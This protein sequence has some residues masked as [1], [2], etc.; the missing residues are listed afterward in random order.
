MP[1]HYLVDGYNVV[2]KSSL[3]RP[4]ALRDFETAREMFI[5]KVV[6]FCL[7]SRQ[8]VTV[9]FDGRDAFSRVHEGRNTRGVQ[10]LEVVYSPDG[11]SADAVIERMVYA[12]PKRLE[13][14]VVSNDGGLRQLCRGLGAL[15]MEP[16]HFIRTVRAQQGVLRE[17]IER[18]SR[19]AAQ[20][21]LLEDRLDGASFDRLKALRDNLDKKKKPGG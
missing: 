6:N 17:G 19:A 13:C 21:A 20:P 1:E 10:G 18:Q 8:R 15:T 3:L 14:V 7:V 11:L 9:V 5:E 16:D 4:V 12:A 2:H